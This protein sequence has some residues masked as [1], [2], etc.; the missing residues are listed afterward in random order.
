MKIVRVLKRIKNNILL[1]CRHD[2]S[3]IVEEKADL[4]YHTIRHTETL[5]QT[6]MVFKQDDSIHIL[7]GGESWEKILDLSK[8][9]V[10]IGDGEL[11]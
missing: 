1:L 9:I 3:N 4:I 11:A 7:S 8:S 10:R 5:M 2:L 6:N